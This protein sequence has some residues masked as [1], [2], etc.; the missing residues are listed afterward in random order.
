MNAEQMTAELR[1]LADTALA[2]EKNAKDRLI[3]ALNEQ[4]YCSE[5]AMRDF[6]KYQG[7]AKPWHRILS[8]VEQGKDLVKAARLELRRSTD[9]LIHV[10][11]SDD[12]GVHA[13]KNRAERDGIRDFL[14]ATSYLLKD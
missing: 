13:E 14:N 2:N 4:S 10:G 9:T 8:A 1:K 11:E 6:L 7:K 5:G 3:K 12:Y